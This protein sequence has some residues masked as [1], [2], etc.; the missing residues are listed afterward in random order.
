MLRY[1]LIGVYVT[2]VTGGTCSCCA[3]QTAADVCQRLTIAQN[4]FVAALSQGQMDFTVE[5]NLVHDGKSESFKGTVIW[6]YPSIRFDLTHAFADSPPVEKTIID[7]SNEIIVWNRSTE[8]VFRSI[9]RKNSYPD[10]LRIAP[11]Q[12]WTEIVGQVPLVDALDRVK[13]DEFELK[14][15]GTTMVCT[16]LPTKLVTRIETW[17][18]TNLL[19]SYRSGP[20]DAIRTIVTWLDKS[21]VMFPENMQYGTNYGTSSE[22]TVSITTYNHTTALSVSDDA[23]SFASIDLDEVSAIVTLQ[24]GKPPQRKHLRTRSETKDIIRLGEYLKKYGFASQE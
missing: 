7:N 5:R 14:V 12:C 6:S 23:F 21:G 3:A 20:G 18:D 15:I 8:E 24:Q 1:L 19:E 2:L 11:W 10:C 13:S 9:D 17:R 16:H 4:E 22:P